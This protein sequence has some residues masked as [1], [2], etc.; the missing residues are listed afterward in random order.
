M[1]KPI[2]AVILTKYMRRSAFSIISSTEAGGLMNVTAPML[3]VAGHLFFCIVLK[4]AFELLDTWACSIQ[5]LAVEG[6]SP[7]RRAITSVALNIVMTNPA[8]KH[9]SVSPVLCP[10][11][12]LTVLK[13]SISI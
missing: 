1:L 8:T 6:S 7:P 12:S 3:N 10:K 11:V 13:L 4:G 2:F 5:S 9:R